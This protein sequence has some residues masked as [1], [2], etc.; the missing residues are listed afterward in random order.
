MDVQLSVYYS[1]Y[2]YVQLK[3][4]VF[5]DHCCYFRYSKELWA[6]REGSDL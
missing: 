2:V 6:Q 4:T 1:T 3:T 5:L